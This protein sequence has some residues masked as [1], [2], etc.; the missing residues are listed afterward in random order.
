MPVSIQNGKVEFPA[1]VSD[2]HCGLID[3]NFIT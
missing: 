3:L 1:L 2:N